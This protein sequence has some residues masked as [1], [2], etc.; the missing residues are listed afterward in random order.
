M[1][2]EGGVGWGVGCNDARCYLQAKMIFFGG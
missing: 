2:L 1:C